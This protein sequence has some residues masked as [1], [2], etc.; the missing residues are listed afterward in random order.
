MWDVTVWEARSN[1]SVG[2]PGLFP[3]LFLTSHSTGTSTVSTK[4]YVFVVG[5]VNTVPYKNDKLT[6]TVPDLIQ[7]TKS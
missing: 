4:D 7:V 1:V 6:F 5:S 2:E 3:F